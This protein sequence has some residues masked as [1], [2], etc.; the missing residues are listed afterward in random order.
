MSKQL[1][2]RCTLESD[3]ILNVKSASEKQNKTLDFIPGNNFLGIAAGKLYNE[4]L[5]PE[6]CRL[7]FHSGLV[8]FGDA[9]PESGNQRSVRIPAAYYYPKGRKLTEGCYISYLITDE[10]V[11]WKQCRSGFYV[12]SSENNSATEV[13]TT[14]VY[15]IKSAYD[16][17]QRR[18]KDET[19]YGYESLCKGLS[20]LFEVDFD[21]SLFDK[22]SQQVKESLIGNKRIGRSRTAQYGQVII[23][24]IDDINDYGEVKTGEQSGDY[25]TVYADG[26]LLFLDKD[27]SLPTFRPSAEN[28]GL[29]SDWTICWDKCQIRTFQY[30]PWNYKRQAF[31]TD[32]CGIEK[33]SVLVLQ[34]KSQPAERY[35][36][37]YVGSYRNEGFGK[38]IYNPDFLNVAPNSSDGKTK[39]SIQ[40]PTIVDDNLTDINS[41]KKSTLISYIEGQQKY[42]TNIAQV[43][44]TVN[45]LVKNYI[46]K[47]RGEAF[48][49]QWGTIRSIALQYQTK[50][51]IEKQLLE[52][53]KGYLV[54][55]KAAEKWTEERKH[56]FDKF[57]NKENCMEDRYVRLGIVNLASEMAKKATTKK[58]Q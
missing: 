23:E 22:F 31:D 54:H 9:H 26:R 44:S 8:R 53:N 10:N 34:P 17:E 20:F 39:Y 5:T 48:A 32:R 18:S 50:A 24:C 4:T 14:T 46:D 57:F 35:E 27:T 28:L 33:G 25:F 15:A 40:S 43:Y 47:F 41:T 56:I 37:G 38:I 52:N 2:F 36:S 7:L 51:E 49:S 29:P 58:V 19:M 1:H 12:F 55:G 6:D 3:V 11:Q 21:D 16:R 45:S 13:E 30:A 42:D